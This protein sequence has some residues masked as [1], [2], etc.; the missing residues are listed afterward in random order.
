MKKAIAL[1]AMLLAVLF[2]SGCANDA[3]TETMFFGSYEQD[4][5]LSNGPEPIEWIVLHKDSE[6]TLLLAK[7]ILEYLPYN[8]AYDSV[9]LVYWPD[10][11]LRAWLGGE[12]YETAFT[13]AE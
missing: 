13:E 4:N 12:F 1:T 7:D 5:D 11:T 10:A 2:V 6:K 3:G 9:S 8:E